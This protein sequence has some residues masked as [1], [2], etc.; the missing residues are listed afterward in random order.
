MVLAEEGQGGGSTHMSDNNFWEEYRKERDRDR[1]WDCVF[2]AGVAVAVLVLGI[3][4][5]ASVAVDLYLK[6]KN[7]GSRQV[8][9]VEVIKP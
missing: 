2:F 6:V 8:H 9:A 1:F 3:V 4:A 7:N 5:T